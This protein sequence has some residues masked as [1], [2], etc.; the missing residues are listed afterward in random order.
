MVR[1]VGVGAV[2]PLPH[3]S[4]GIGCWAWADEAANDAAPIQT[5]TLKHLLIKI[6]YHVTVF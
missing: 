4:T 6:R 1:G 2:E 5:R 3:G